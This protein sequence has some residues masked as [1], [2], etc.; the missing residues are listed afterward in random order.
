ML[1]IMF[2]AMIPDEAEVDIY[3]KTGTGVDGDF[4]YSR[5]YKATPDSLT[6]KSS[7]DFNDITATIENLAPFDSVM[8]KLVMRS[9]NKAK[10]PRIKDFRVIACAA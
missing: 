10:V 9:I 6:Q 3:Y 2:A 8:V 7:S 4:I 5:Y 1:K